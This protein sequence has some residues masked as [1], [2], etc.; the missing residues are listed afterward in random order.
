MTHILHCVTAHPGYF[1][2]GFTLVFFT[3]NHNP[4]HPEL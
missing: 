2:A 3:L 4:R 1:L